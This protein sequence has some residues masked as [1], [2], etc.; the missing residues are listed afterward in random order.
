MSIYTPR[1]TDACLCNSGRPYRACCSRL[2]KL[3]KNASQELRRRHWLKTLADSVT[4]VELEA[5]KLDILDQI[6]DR[7]HYD[8]TQG[9]EH[10]AV[11]ETFED[12]L[13]VMEAYALFHFGVD[14]PTTPGNSDEG[15]PVLD[16]DIDS[17]REIDPEERTKGISLAALHLC[18]FENREKGDRKTALVEATKAHFSFYRIEEV[19]E[20]EGLVLH[21]LLLDQAV[22][23]TDQPASMNLEKGWILFS[24]VLNFEGIS[25]LFATADIA[26][27]P[28]SIGPISKV[29][30]LLDKTAE[31]RGEALGQ[32]ALRSLAAVLIRQYATGLAAMQ[33]SQMQEM[34]NM[35]GEIIAPKRLIYTH[36]SDS[37][38][39]LAKLIEGRL[40]RS[41]DEPPYEV[42]QKDSSGAPLEIVIPL[43]GAPG[44]KAAC[45]TVII[46]S[47]TITPKEVTLE[48]NSHERIE[49]LQ[50]MLEEQFSDL[51][52]FECD[53]VVTIA[54][55]LR[56]PT[57]GGFSSGEARPEIAAALKAHMASLQEKWLV[58]PV[59]ALDGMT[60]QE[61]AADPKGRVLLTALLDDFDSR[62]RE[63]QS[64]PMAASFD[65]AELRARLG[66]PKEN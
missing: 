61:A 23:V 66:C 26:L 8:L 24:K 54:E 13:D 19:L 3:P 6:Y 28:L 41:T 48:A 31:E 37:I 58:Q 17:E 29:K 15:S 33:Y 50:S 30:E 47:L 5:D 10:S 16:E 2:S 7:A 14:L 63:V 59:P 22:T 44:N 43:S 60:P 38:G 25:V 21:D 53:E 49:R 36:T 35:D 9:A 40:N 45:G 1:P 34:R 42:T 39:A 20:G 12:F 55:G 56:P 27:P 51:L 11:S 46:G 57:S 64:K 4:A 65:V 32:P 18:K 52:V 62:S